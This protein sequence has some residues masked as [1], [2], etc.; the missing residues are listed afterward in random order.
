MMTIAWICVWLSLLIALE[1]SVHLITCFTMA[2]MRGGAPEAFGF[3]KAEFPIKHGA[4]IKISTDRRTSLNVSPPNVLIQLPMF[5]EGSQSAGLIHSMATL[6]WPRD[7][8]L[9]QVLDD[10]TDDRSRGCVDIAVQNWREHGIP[11]EI[12]RRSNREGYKAGALKEGME[13]SHIQGEYEFIAIFDADFRPDADFLLKTIPYFDSPDVGLVQA[14]WTFTNSNESFLTRMQEIALN[15]HCKCEQFSRFAAHLFFNFNGTAG[16]WR[17]RTIV[18]AGGWSG[19]TVTEDMDLSLRAHLAGWKSVYLRDVGCDNEI[20]SDYKAYRNQQFRWTCGPMQVW[21]R[22]PIWNDKIPFAQLTVT[23]ALPRLWITFFF[24]VSYLVSNTLTA[25]L[26]VLLMPISVLY[27]DLVVPITMMAIFLLP[28]TLGTCLFTPT[29]RIDRYIGF[30]LFQNVMSLLRLQAVLSGLL[31]TQRA[32]SWI[33]TTK[34]GSAAAS[35][36]VSRKYSIHWLES[37]LGAVYF[38]AASYTV[39]HPFTKLSYEIPLITYLCLQG[40]FFF[41]QGLGFFRFLTKQAPETES[42]NLPAT[43][44]ALD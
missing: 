14:R 2:I 25:I 5:N 35:K 22:T 38:A 26:A 16:V 8:L 13:L 23:E 4:A 41:F 30:V 27:P 7:R 15:Y 11:I 39:L 12:H 37:A 18:E 1:R 29:W 44:A 40:T 28:P 31:N 32:N 34:K 19:S 21:R 33:V 43:V 6:N 3:P 20:P 42:T 9:I 36:T 24:L 10:S 17:T